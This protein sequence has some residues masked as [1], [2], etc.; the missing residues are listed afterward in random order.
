MQV[1]TVLK[2][3]DTPYDE[4]YL[5]H[6]NQD[7]GLYS[8]S[9]K[10][11]LLGVY[12]ADLGYATAYEQTEESLEI[13]DR[14]QQLASDLGITNSFNP[15]MVKRFEANRSNQDSLSW[16]IL[17]GFEKAHTYFQHN[18]SEAMGIL[19]ISGC[20]VEGLYLNLA[21]DSLYAY[22]EH[23]ALLEQQQNYLKNTILLLLKFG[24]Q[25][26]AL[27]PLADDLITILGEFRRLDA[28]AKPNWNGEYEVNTKLQGKINGLKTKVE[29]IRT[30]M[31]AAEI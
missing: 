3:N 9:K 13:I 21:S 2:I 19:I 10:A 16:L 7:L 11:E 12:L 1:A 6:L 18:D 29:A 5:E 30:A 26:P 14:T 20:L 25:D 22:S 17:D 4:N 8:K 23:M 28:Y 24:S 31:I 27:E 15:S